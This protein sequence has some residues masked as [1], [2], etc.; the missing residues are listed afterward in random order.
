MRIHPTFH[1]S[2]IKPVSESPLKVLPQ[3]SSLIIILLFWFDAFWTCTAGVETSI[4]WWIGKDTVLEIDIG[5]P[6]LSTSTDLISSF[7]RA[8]P[9]NRFRSPRGDSWEGCSVGFQCFSC[10]NN[11]LGATEWQGRAILPQ[12][13]LILANDRLVYIRTLVSS[14]LLEN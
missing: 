10:S 6:C 14:S 11:F 7:Y 5:L 1:I 8:H 4:T 13:I 2:K 3:L 9:E 12:L